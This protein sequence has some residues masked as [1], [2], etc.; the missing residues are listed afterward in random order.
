MEK[1]VGLVVYRDVP[2]GKAYLLLQYLGGHWDF[3]KGHVKK[4]ESEKETAARE[5]R[6]ETHIADAEI[7]DQFR[8]RVQYSFRRNNKLVTKEVIYY[9]AKTRTAAVKLSREHRGSVWL[10]GDAA[11]DRLTFASS[12]RILHEGR[13]IIE[14]DNNGA[15]AGSG[16]T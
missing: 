3:P 11:R 5:L 7:N 16:Q 9:I 1:S 12:R 8:D 15:A 13:S 6:E 2:E 4:G 14:K 10:P